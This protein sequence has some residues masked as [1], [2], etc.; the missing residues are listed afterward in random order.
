VQ[1]GRR[2][3]G[4]VALAAAA[5]LALLALSRPVSRTTVIDQ[6]GVAIVES[7]W[8][9]DL[10]LVDPVGTRSPLPGSAVAYGVGVVLGVVLGL[11][12]V[13]VAGV[14]RWR[15]RSSPGW[16]W[17]AAGWLI[18][19]GV[20]VLADTAARL[21]RARVILAPAVAGELTVTATSGPWLVLAAG[22]LAA[23]AA[24]SRERRPRPA[25]VEA[26]VLTEWTPVGGSG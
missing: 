5:V 18:T 22:V 8:F 4:S 16:S 25:R 26:P 14:L 10:V 11:V 6:R 17:V 21:D 7:G 1:P 19:T 23:A 3:L 15:S 2:D 12:L 13:A 20:L 24:R 9:G